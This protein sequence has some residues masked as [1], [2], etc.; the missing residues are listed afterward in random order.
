MVLLRRKTTASKKAS[1]AIEAP[2]AQCFWV[3]NGPVLKNIAELRLA[4]ER[5]ND[6]QFAH[7]VNSGKNDFTKW[8]V[9]VLHLTTLAHD[10]HKAMTRKAAI[11]V[12]EKHLR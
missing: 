4:L 1:V 2:P 11:K 3:H 7:H 9:D 8:I 12:L 10:L 6:A 5:M